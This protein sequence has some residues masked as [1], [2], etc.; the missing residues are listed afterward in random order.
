MTCTGGVGTAVP[1]AHSRNLDLTSR[2]HAVAISVQ[3]GEGTVQIVQAAVRREQGG[4]A[5][6][7]RGLVVLLVVLSTKRTL[8]S[9]GAV[10]AVG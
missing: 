7:C 10:G 3:E 9:V 8:F 2:K 6:L 4:L 1:A 5:I